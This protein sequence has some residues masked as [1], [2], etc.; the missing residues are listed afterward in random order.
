MKFLKQ[1][2]CHHHWERRWAKI[3]MPFPY[4]ECSKC[5]KI[6]GWNL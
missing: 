1:V 6:R 5:G 3:V 2:F 4:E